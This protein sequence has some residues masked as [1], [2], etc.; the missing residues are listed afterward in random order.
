MSGKT[1]PLRASE[2]STSMLRLGKVSLSKSVQKFSASHLM[3]F[4]TDVGNL[5]QLSN[6]ELCRA[7][8]TDPVKKSVDDGCAPTD[9]RGLI[10]INHTVAEGDCR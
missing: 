3:P 10:Q 1:S 4:Q 6:T 8:D 5:E 2:P 7:Q 9:V